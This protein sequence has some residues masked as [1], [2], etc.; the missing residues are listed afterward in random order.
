[1]ETAE[2]Q[3][4]VAVSFVP[5]KKRVG[6]PKLTNEDRV[7][8]EARRREYQASYRGTHDKKKYMEHCDVCQ[9]DV[10]C[11][12]T[13]VHSNK[14]KLKEYENEIQEMKTKHENEIKEMGWKME[15]QMYCYEERIDRI[16]HPEPEES[17]FGCR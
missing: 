6:R 14:H 15:Y 4:N 12:K 10:T 2:I 5:A 7:L 3:P 17:P 13:H 8:S 1:M 9:K 11:M 16:I